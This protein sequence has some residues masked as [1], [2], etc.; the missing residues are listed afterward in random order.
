[1]ATTNLLE[2][3]GNQIISRL[4]VL[5]KNV[6]NKLDW[7]GPHSSSKYKFSFRSY[8]N[9]KLKYSLYFAPLCYS[10]PTYS[11]NET[12]YPQIVDT[13]LLA[14]YITEGKFSGVVIL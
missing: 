4:S 8:F 12:N 11:D 3:A 1:M 14:S 5:M 13:H 6:I 7:A 10:S 2:E 9:P